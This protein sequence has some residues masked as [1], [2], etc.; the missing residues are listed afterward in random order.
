MAQEDE[1]IKDATASLNEIVQVSAR[2]NHFLNHD[3]GLLQADFFRYYR[4]NLYKPCR[5]FTDQHYK[6]NNEDCGVVSVHD[7][8]LVKRLSDLELETT[9][10][11]L[12]SCS[13]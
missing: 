1:R 4:V 9:R 7:S 8:Q 3:R 11:D 2:L 12:P 5:F 13:R 6:C 10:A